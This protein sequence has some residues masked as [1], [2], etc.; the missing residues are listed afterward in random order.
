MPA[1]S[2]IL[3][4]YRSGETAAGT[5]L[6]EAMAGDVLRIVRAYR[7]RES[8]EDLLQTIFIRMFQNLHQYSAKAPFEH[9]V[10]RLTVN[11]CRNRL[12]FEKVR[13]EIR[14][15]D[16]SEEQAKL[17]QTAEVRDLRSEEGSQAAEIIDLLLSSLK[18]HERLLVQ[19]LYIQGLSFKEVSFATGSSVPL[20]KVQAFRLRK[21]LRK[22]YE[23]LISPGT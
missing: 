2:E 12:K 17:I 5:E 23:R 9:W 22:S 13:P 6:M 19:M 3:S 10:S 20:L 1:I 4:R 14:W 11:V 7:T 18:P 15:A 16:L 8:E 21:K